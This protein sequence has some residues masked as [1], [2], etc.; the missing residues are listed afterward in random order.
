MAKVLVIYADGTQKVM[1]LDE[2][3]RL[4]KLSE[5]QI[6]SAIRTGRR[7]KT[8]MY[9]EAVDYEVRGYDSDMA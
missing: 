4:Y 7:L 9:D 1:E 8:M 5:K 6:M 2:A 3:C